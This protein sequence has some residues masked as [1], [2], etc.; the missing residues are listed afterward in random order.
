[1]YTISGSGCRQALCNWI[2][3]IVGCVTDPYPDYLVY[4]TF[5]GPNGTSLDAH[6]PEKDDVGAG[7]VEVAGN[8]A[9]TGGALPG[10]GTGG[11]IATIAVG[12]AGHYAEA[13][14][15]L[16][17]KA[18]GVIAR[19]VDST[20][21]WVALMNGVTGAIDLYIN[22]AGFTNMGSIAATWNDGDRL[23]L[24]CSGDVLTVLQNDV[25]KIQITNA[26]FNT[27]TVVGVR[28]GYDAGEL[29]DDFRAGVA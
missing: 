15:T 14:L 8:W 3:T 19:Y 10:S 7:W 17:G 20:H 22:N 21:F 26:T 5:T 25:Q 16:Q 11:D 13:E 6:T 12:V 28:E 27:A 4:D 2:K 29:W 1:M 18:P 24:S 23:R 9:I